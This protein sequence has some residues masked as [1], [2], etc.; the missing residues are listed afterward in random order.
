MLLDKIDNTNLKLFN[1]NYSDNYHT[2]KNIYKQQY[3]FNHFFTSIVA[4]V[5]FVTLL[6]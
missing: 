1:P 3:D 2:R 6:N 4:K 5:I